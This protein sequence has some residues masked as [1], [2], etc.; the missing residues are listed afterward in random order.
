MLFRSNSGDSDAFLR[1]VRQTLC[2]SRCSRPEHRIR[3]PFEG[4]AQWR[5][6]AQLLVEGK[7]SPQTFEE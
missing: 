5:K 6:V 1:S 7:I 4:Q 3:M 2:G